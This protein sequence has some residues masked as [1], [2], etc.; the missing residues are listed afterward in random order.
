MLRSTNLAAGQANYGCPG[1]LEAHWVEQGHNAGTGDFPSA[2]TNCCHV[3]I[4]Y[5]RHEAVQYLT[6]LVTRMGFAH[7]PPGVE[8]VDVQT[9]S[10]LAVQCT[11]QAGRLAGNYKRTE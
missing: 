6:A 8:F 10:T 5:C 9:G 7:A 3:A 11:L 4:S 1:M 2:A